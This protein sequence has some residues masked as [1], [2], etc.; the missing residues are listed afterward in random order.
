MIMARDLIG[1]VVS[2]KKLRLETPTQGKP[3][4]CEADALAIYIKNSNGKERKVSRTDLEEFCREFNTSG[5]R[6]A[7]HY[8]SQSFNASYLIAITD[9][10]LAKRATPPPAQEG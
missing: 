10:L 5:S 8:S 7:S 9:A 4:E 3:F 2:A 1:F 6:A